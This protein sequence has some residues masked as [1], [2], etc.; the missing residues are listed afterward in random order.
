MSPTEKDTCL[1]PTVTETLSSGLMQ[2]F[3]T[4]ERALPGTM[5]CTAST[6]QLS[7]AAFRRASR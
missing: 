3:S 7:T 5:N 2:I 1:L 4:S 6:S